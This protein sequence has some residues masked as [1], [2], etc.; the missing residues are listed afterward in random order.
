M[1]INSN[2]YPKPQKKSVIVNDLK[3]PTQTVVPE[4]ELPENPLEGPIYYNESDKNRYQWN[5]DEWVLMGGLQSD[6]N[7]TDDSKADFIKN[8]PT[9]PAAQ[10]QADWNAVSGLGR[11]LNKPKIDAEI[12]QGFGYYISNGSI[13]KILKGDGSYFSSSQSSAFITGEAIRYIIVQETICIDNINMIGG[14]KD[15]SSATSYTGIHYNTHTISNLL[16]CTKKGY[17]SKGDTLVLYITFN[18]QVHLVNIIECDNVLTEK[19]ISNNTWD[20]NFNYQT[21]SSLSI[22]ANTTLTLSGTN[23]DSN[24]RITHLIRVDNTGASNVTL[25]LA[26]ETNINYIRCLSN[27]ISIPANN[28]LELSCYVTKETINGVEKY[29]A[30]VTEY[31]GLQLY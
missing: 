12:Y 13:L 27:Q 19:A 31:N 17:L 14:F 28:S 24:L 30:N 9:I 3:N 4:K 5:G 22:S 1:I 8:K 29:V 16:Q 18:K 26:K 20:L 21:L 23:D 10:V 7:Q 15:E 6:W 11:I 2:T 25:T